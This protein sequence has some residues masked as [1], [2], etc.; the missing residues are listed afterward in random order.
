MNGWKECF[1]QNKSFSN[2]QSTPRNYK[3]SNTYN[4]CRINKIEFMRQMIHHISFELS[5]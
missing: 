5:T 4:S 3:K 1:I 2:K